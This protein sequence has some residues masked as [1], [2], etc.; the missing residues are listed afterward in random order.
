[1]YASAH[2]TFM[3]SDNGVAWCQAIIW[4]NAG[5]NGHTNFSEQQF[6]LKNMH[7]R[8]L[9]TMWG[10]FSWPQCINQNCSFYW[11]V[12]VQQACVGDTILHHIDNDNFHI[13]IGN[14]HFLSCW[15]S[16]WFCG[17]MMT[18]LR[19]ISQ[20]MFLYHGIRKQYWCE[21]WLICIHRRKNIFPEM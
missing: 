11:Y 3:G 1:M 17:S 8:M 10:P 5:H 21:S 18:R 9:S 19:F 4:P 12:I 13:A 20:L 15:P 14:C 2:Q 16:L 7:L 6:S